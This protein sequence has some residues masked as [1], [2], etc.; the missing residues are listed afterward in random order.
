M[1]SPSTNRLECYAETMSE[2]VLKNPKKE[3]TYGI[4]EL[5]P[6]QGD[7]TEAEYIELTAFSNHLIELSDG[8]LEVLPMP[9]ERHQRMITYLLFKLY[10]FVLEHKL[11]M[12]LVAP[13]KVK[14]WEGKIREPG[15]VFMRAENADRRGE[16]VW[17]GADLVVEVVSPD[18]PKRD[19]VDKFQEYARAGIPEYWLVDPRDDS[20]TVY[21][22]PES[23]AAYRQLGRLT[24]GAACSQLLEGFCVDVA[25]L[26]EV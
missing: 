6:C 22:L 14:L 21:T 13:L 7:W 3:P 4:L 24:D 18:D 26:F 23:G 5:F 25:T 19:T 9:S 2:A 20:V 10:S 11:G 15:I 16:Q 1:D 8:R 12:V 17:Q